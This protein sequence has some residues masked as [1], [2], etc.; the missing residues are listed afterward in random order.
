MCEC[1]FCKKWDK[2]MC[3]QCTLNNFHAIFNRLEK[4]E[5]QMEEV[6]DAIKGLRRSECKR[7][8]NQRARA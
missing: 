5:R 3:G 2:V 1:E 4:I 7:E 8:V 6:A